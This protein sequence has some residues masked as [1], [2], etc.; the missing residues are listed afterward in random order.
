MYLL[1]KSWIK[2][3]TKSV[4]MVSE[5]SEWVIKGIKTYCKH[6]WDLYLNYQSRNNQIM[7]IHYRKYFKSLNRLNICITVNRCYSQIFTTMRT[8][9]L[10]K[11]LWSW[12]KHYS[13]HI[14]L[15]LQY[16]HLDQFQGTLKNWICNC[17]CDLVR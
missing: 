5:N 15:S 9:N 6:K 13:S 11:S 8:Y 14:C 1:N 2:Y 7:K 3:P 17:T 12:Y 10:F 4:K 16:L